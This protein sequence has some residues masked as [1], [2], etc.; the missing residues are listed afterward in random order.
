MS[1]SYKDAGVDIEAGD[2]FVERIRKLCES[3]YRRGVVGELGDFS[4]FFRV[5]KKRLLAASTDGV[6][7]K[8]KIAEL[9]DKHDTVGI[10][11]VAMCANDVVVTGAEPLFFLDYFACG[12]LDLTVAEQ[13][14][15]G[16]AEGCRQ[17]GCALIGGETA[18]MPGFY[19]PGSYDLAGF[20]VGEVNEE[21][22]LGTHRVKKGNALLGLASTGVHSNGYSLVRRVL[23]EPEPKALEQH[24]EELGC[25]LGEELLRPTRI[26][27][28]LALALKERAGANAMA[29]ITGG[30]LPGNVSRFVP[31]GLT[32]RLDCKA[33]PRPA[34]FN[35]IQ[36][37]SGLDWK[38]MADTFNLGLGLVVA[39]PPERLEDALRTAAS[40]GV[41]AWP[42][43]E[44]V[45]RRDGQGEVELLNLFS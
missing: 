31:P 10:D 27:V 39:L 30:G 41:P 14:L 28:K 29:H 34:I 24:I 37:R 12:R 6:G 25:T 15:S 16:I 36:R 22:R 43:G 3:T 40:F 9:M 19:P 8:L 23:V 32:A 33:W 35:L 13:V 18:E 7:T 17:A 42:V 26:Y 11:L 44:I 45:E 4:G 21:Q 2:L 20:C 38:G 1:V 5:G